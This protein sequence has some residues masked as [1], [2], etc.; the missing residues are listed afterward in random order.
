M[1]EIRLGLYRAEVFP[2]ENPRYNA[3][4]LLVHGLWAGAWCW[5]HFGSF[6]AHRGWEVI[7]PDL[8]GRPGSREAAIGDVELEDYLEDVRAWIAEAG[9]PPVVIGHDLG[10]LLALAAPRSIAC[11]AVIALAPPFAAAHVEAYRRRLRAGSGWFRRRTAPPAEG[12]APPP[13]LQPDS[14]R[15]VRSLLAGEPAL[16]PLDVPALVVA[17]SRD[18]WLDPAR[19]EAAARALGCAFELRAAAHWDLEGRGFE[20]QVDVLQRWLVRAIGAPLLRLSGF[21]NA[22]DERSEE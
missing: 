16:E 20:R 13:G 9:D 19:L 7:A 22:D 5:R 18:P 8:R 10:G 3:R 6:F 14:A 17:G 21:E 11:R 4:L 12:D 15:V 2:P 1:L